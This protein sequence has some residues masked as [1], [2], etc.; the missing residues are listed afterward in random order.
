M[1]TCEEP[2]VTVFHPSL[3]LEDGKYLVLC[4]VG[5]LQKVEGLRALRV[6]GRQIESQMVKPASPVRVLSRPEVS[7]DVGCEE[8]ALHLRVRR[9][10]NP[11]SKQVQALEEQI[12]RLRGQERAANGPQKEKY[13]EELVRKLNEHHDALDKAE[14]REMAHAHVILCTCTEAG[15]SRVRRHVDAAHVI[16]D[17]SSTCLEAEVLV[18]LSSVGP[19]CRNVVLLGDHKQLAPVVRNKAARKLG[20]ARS[21]FEVMF[22]GRAHRAYVTHVLETQYRM[23]SC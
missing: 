10:Q 16:I 18:V 9:P 4:L 11:H 17:E 12:E 5:M 22:E 1:I 23:V 13:R 20:L 7:V 3:G 21:L 19:R 14:K 2:T 15:S 8:I 6:Y